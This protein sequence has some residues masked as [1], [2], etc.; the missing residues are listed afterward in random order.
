MALE[1]APSVMAGAR[2]LVAV[3]FIFAASSK[4]QAP[5]RF[6]RDLRSFGIP[7]RGSMWVAWLTIAV[8]VL[9][10]VALI[11]RVAQPVPGM[12][13]VVLLGVFTTAVAWRWHRTGAFDCGCFGDTGSTRPW[14]IFPRNVLLGVLALTAAR[15]LGPWT[16]TTVISGAM[17][18]ATAGVAVALVATATEPKVWSVQ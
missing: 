7:L 12:L 18:A 13:S 6:A 5:D 1:I 4:A 8:E 9:L 16:L 2:I 3:V 10:A 14:L 15:D 11:T 17:L